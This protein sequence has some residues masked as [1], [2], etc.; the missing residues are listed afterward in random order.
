MKALCVQMAAVL[1]CAHAWAQEE[2]AACDLDPTADIDAPVLRIDCD[3]I[4]ERAAYTMA[5]HEGMHAQVAALDAMV[6]TIK[7]QREHMRQELTA[8][9]LVC[10]G[11]VDALSR[12][13]RLCSRALEQVADPP[14]R[15]TWFGL[16]AASAV[17]A[18]VIVYFAV[19]Q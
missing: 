11:K 12:D 8:D 16:G 5:A 15:A 19:G 9:R 6:D 7:A 3:L 13:L 14:S 4:G 18:G 10:A 17:V 1:L 2:V